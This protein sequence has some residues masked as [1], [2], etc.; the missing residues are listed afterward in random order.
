M[1]TSNIGVCILRNIFED[2]N[3]SIDDIICLEIGNDI[4]KLIVGDTSYLR[5]DVIEIFGVVR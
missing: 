4:L 1:N 2:R 5:F 3:D